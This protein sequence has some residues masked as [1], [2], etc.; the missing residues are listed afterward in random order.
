MVIKYGEI[1]FL[2]LGFLCIAYGIIVRSIGSGTGFFVAWCG[3][4]ACFL[5]F[6]FSLRMGWWDLLPGVIKYII[7]VCVGIILIAFIIVEGMVLSGFSKHGDQDVDLIIVL[8]AQIYEKGPS[9]ALKYRLDEAI[10][11]LEENPDLKCIVTGGQGY[12]EPYAEAVGMAKYMEEKGVPKERIILEDESKTTKENI[13]NSIKI[14]EN[15]LGMDINDM[16]IGIVTNNFHV[17]RGL[18]IAKKAGI[19]NACGI[20]C[21]STLFFLPN[22]M[23]REFFGEIK[24]LILG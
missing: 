5:L 18:Q 10:H 22:N 1:T 15:E 8:G 2:I 16:K 19:K 6:F 13:A 21:P 20:S 17:F 3:L 11:Q 14:I 12:N 24:Y 23:F 7:Y 4:G 9:V